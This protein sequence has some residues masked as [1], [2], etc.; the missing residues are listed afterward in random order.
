MPKK[1]RSSSGNK[2]K[3]KI[4]VIGSARKPRVKNVVKN[5]LPK[6][7]RYVEI[8]DVVSDESLDLSKIRVDL[9][10]V[11][12]GD[13]TILSAARMLGG[14]VAP[15]MGVDMGWRGFLAQSSVST[16]VRDLKNFLDGKVEIGRRMML[17][18][19]LKRKGKVIS[20]FRA[21]NDVVV[22]ALH[23]ARMVKLRLSVSGDFVH[24]YPCDGLIISTPTGSTAHALSAG[25]P[26]LAPGSEMF[27]V[28]PIASHA[29]VDR[30]IV[31]PGKECLTITHGRNTRE[32]SVTIDGQTDSLMTDGDELEVKRSRRD[33]RV[34]EFARDSFY[35]VVRK[36][37][38]WRG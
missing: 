2:R 7:R 32:S 4:L 17:Q 37:L 10:I 34:V 24:E 30:P 35:E 25:G 13:G 14:N 6:L 33:F 38:S 28:V 18:A 5:L 21:L 12:G 16:L 22:S 29:F 23:F 3:P 20:R 15:V 19:S 31:V 27:V 26:I 36:K 11:F 1:S 8:V 9:V